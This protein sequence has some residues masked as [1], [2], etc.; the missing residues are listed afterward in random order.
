MH[1]CKISVCRIITFSQFTYYSDRLVFEP[2]NLESESDFKSKSIHIMSSPSSKSQ[3]SSPGHYSIIKLTLV[4]KI[5]S[6]LLQESGCAWVKGLMKVWYHSVFSSTFPFAKF[7]FCTSFAI[8]I[9]LN[10]S[11]A[12]AN[13]LWICENHPLKENRISK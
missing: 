3:R 5:R 2:S 12:K 11:E 1:C 7:T 10:M 4:E 9:P 6:Q 13:N 8:Y